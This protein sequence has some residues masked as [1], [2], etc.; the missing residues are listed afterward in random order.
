MFI[1]FINFIDLFIVLYL[2]NNLEKFKKQNINIKILKI[3]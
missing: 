2:M 3:V 1:N